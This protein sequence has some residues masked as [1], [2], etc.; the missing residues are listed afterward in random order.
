MAELALLSPR[1]KLYSLVPL[2]SAWPSTTIL[3]LE[4]F[5]NQAACALK[6]S[7]EAVV[8]IDS[9][10]AKKTLSGTPS[11][12]YLTVSSPVYTSPWIWPVTSGAV[13]TSF[14]VAQAVK[15]RHAASIRNPF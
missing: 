12:K 13:V 6:V 9:F 2:S 3:I 7:L 1:A 5:L 11:A 10:V 8:K 4:F 14:F 15:T